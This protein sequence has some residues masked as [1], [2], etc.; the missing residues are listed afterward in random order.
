[1]GTLVSIVIDNFDYAR[2]LPMAIDSALA[3]TYEQVEVV[4]VDDGST[5][6]SWEV[7]TGYGSRV[8]GVRKDNGG[9]ASALNAG[10]A[11]S[12]GDVVI[13]LDSDDVLYP[14]AAADVV[15]ALGPRTAKVH[16]VLDE[17]DA[18]GQPLGRT[19][20]SEAATLAEGDVLPSLLRQG[21]Y[22]CPVM[23]GNAYPRWVL[24]RIMPMPEASFASTADGYLV[25]L[26]ALHGP[27]AVTTRPLGLYRRHGGNAWGAKPSGASLSKHT[28][29]EMARY[30]ELRKAAAAL[31]LDVPTRLDLHDYS[32]LRTRLASLRLAGASHPVP[33]D[34][35][36]L[37]VRAGIRSLW[38]WAGVSLRRRVLFTVWFVVV[39]FGPLP[40]AQRAIHWLYVAS[41]RPGGSRVPSVPAPPPQSA[42]PGPRSSV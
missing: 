9:Q 12:T 26:A 4:V 7:I 24:Q 23:S 31:G 15:A 17:V 18:S 29:R 32:G 10:F 13:F 40:L 6:G 38:R 37:L 33:D 28:R 25:A 27:V 5:D 21:R 30:D 1:M 14:T 42:P 3:Q 19:N 11:A 35:A 34:T 36:G 8:V 22:V 2:F 16:G 20:P 41:A 39:G